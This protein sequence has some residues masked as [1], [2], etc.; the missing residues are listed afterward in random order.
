M[1]NY[2]PIKIMLLCLVC[3]GSFAQQQVEGKVTSFLTGDLLPGVN[4]LIKGTTIGTVTDTEGRYRIQISGPE[5]VLVFSFIGYDSYETAA[6][7]RTVIDVRLEE[8]IETLSEVVVVAFGTAKKATITGALES[9]QA[10]ELVKQPQANVTNAMQG[11]A[12]GLQVLEGNGQPGSSA[13][14]LVRGIGSLQAGTEPLIVV[15]GAVFNGG[16]SQLN[17]NDIESINVLK[18]ASSAALYGSRAANGVI[19]I[20]TKKGTGDETRY[21]IDI[22][23]G[24]TENQNPNDFRVMNAAEYVEY[25][26]EAILNS[27]QDPDDPSTGFYLP[28]DQQF[29]TDWVD[30]AFQTGTFN[31]YNF[32]ATGKSGRA[33]FF[34]SLGYFD[35]KGSIIGTDFERVTGTLNLTNRS[36]DKFDYGAK[37]Q[38]AYRNSNNL[39]SNGGRSGQLSGTFQTAPTEPVFATPDLIGGPL[40]GAGFNFDIPSNAQHNSV[41]TAALNDNTSETWSMNSNVN[42]GYNLTPEIRGEALANYYFFSTVNKEST[43]KLYRAETEGGNSSEERVS[44]STF[45]FIGTLAFEKELEDHTLA[46]KAGFETTR[47]RFNSLEV[48]TSG[49]VF[50]NLNDVGLGSV[51]TAEDLSSGFGGSSVAGFFGRAN[52]SF[53]NKLFVSGS[54]RR[55][56]ASNFGPDTR[57]GTFGAV[58]VGYLLSTESFIRDLN[59]FDQLKLRA[60]YGSSGNNRI[61]DFGWRDLYR[62]DILF[63]TATG[64]S[65]GVGT[66]QPSNSELRWEKNLQLDIGLDFSLFNGRLEGTVDYFRR[67]S[68]DLLFNAPLS[69]TTG[70]DAVTVNSGAELLN[71][72]VEV[73]LSGYPVR[74]GNFSWQV[75]GNVAFYDQEITSIPEEVVFTDRIWQEGGRSDNWYLQRYAG[76][77][78][79][80]GDAL[81]FTAEG[82]TSTEYNGDEDRVV[83]GQRTPDTYGSVSNIFSYKNLSLSVMVYYS[84]GSDDYFDLAQ[85]LNTDGANFPANQWVKAL[86]RWQQPGDVTDVPRVLINNPNGDLVS[87]RY[88]YDESYVRLQN[89][90]LSY[91]L[92]T[93]IVSRLGMDGISVNLSG[94]NLLLFSD[95][96]GFDP[97]SEAYPIPRTITLGANL[98]F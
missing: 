45:N 3:S 76:V 42:I 72:G 35:Q 23:T 48:A 75:T 15:D 16:L 90:S 11:L 95:F 31:Q 71:T 89:V 43:G 64:V 66:L 74:K 30:E 44:G 46:V 12:P 13:N 40:E 49:F 34:T 9:I 67:I 21:R 69:Q 63:V 25:Y 83:V 6:G 60:S 97:T 14:F 52:Y 94:Q 91:A 24:I 29:D 68:E 50:G 77:D 86:N 58:G 96:P 65:G 37:V 41:A 85:D 20:T 26:R 73:S 5:D 17:P 36:N 7:S 22:Q 79:N 33:N 78:V 32:S 84:Q 82:S 61:S 55:D 8:N 19:L 38:L 54:L 87:T 56:G 10:D 1:R 57:W 92:P 27:G 51:V 2:L 70:F 18:D 47:Q 98:S 59:L 4:V 28:V 39:I 80:T 88:L 53:K 62:A 81:Y 93:N